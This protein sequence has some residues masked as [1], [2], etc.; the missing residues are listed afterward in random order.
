MN[1]DTSEER[2]LRLV[3]R[4]AVAAQAYQ[5]ALDELDEKR[6]ALHVRVITGLHASIVAEGQAGREALLALTDSGDDTVVGMAAVYAIRLDPS[7]C[8]KVLRRLAKVE[9]L[10][11]FRAS[12]ALERWEQGEW[13]GP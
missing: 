9:G 11:G 6:A 3:S 10:L 1:V 13:D 5:R 4:F 12:V 2:L 7:R 8:L